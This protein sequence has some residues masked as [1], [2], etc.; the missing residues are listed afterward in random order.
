MEGE[1]CE[2][3][4]VENRWRVQYKADYGHPEGSVHNPD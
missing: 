1:E 2:R 3:H 4:D